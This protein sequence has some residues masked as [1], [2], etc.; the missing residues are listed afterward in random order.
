H[1]LVYLRDRDTAPCGLARR[2]PAAPL[3]P[4][5]RLRQRLLHRLHRRLARRQRL[6]AAVELLAALAHGFEQLAE[7]AA[8]GEQ[9][10]RDGGFGDRALGARHARPPP[11]AHD[12]RL[13]RQ[14]REQPYPYPPHGTYLRSLRRSESVNDAPKL[15]DDIALVRTERDPQ[16]RIEA[17]RR[18][19]D[20]RLRL[21]DV[22][23]AHRSHHAH[24]LLQD[25]ARALR[26]VAED[27]L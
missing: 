26:E 2:R 22:L 8:L 16:L 7:A 23:Q 15:D 13:R 20:P 12:D 24:V 1:A 14:A 6:L 9:V 18:R 17:A 19:H 5:R 11:G 27:L 3:H 25:L 21:L 10:G 4:P